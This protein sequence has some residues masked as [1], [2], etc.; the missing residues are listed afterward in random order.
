MP[1]LD[2]TWIRGQFPAL[3]QKVGNHPAVFF[4][5]PGG[6]QVPQRVIEPALCLTADEVAWVVERL[7]LA[8]SST[9]EELSRSKPRPEV[10]VKRLSPFEKWSN[11]IAIAHESHP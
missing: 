10:V 3:A 7:I 1:A 9:A 11:V 2:I 6:T 8:P 4:D 5:G